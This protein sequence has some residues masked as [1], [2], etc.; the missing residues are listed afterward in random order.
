MRV[1]RK[2]DAAIRVLMGLAAAE[3]AGER[4]VPLPRLGKRTSIS[5]PFLQ[6]ILFCLRKA[7]LVQGMRGRIGGYALA[8]PAGRITAG[9]VLRAIQGSVAPTDCSVE[10]HKP[11]CGRG[12]CAIRQ[13]WLRVHRETGRIV[14]R[15]TVKEL[16]KKEKRG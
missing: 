10:G 9:D 11:I 7:R 3:E 16:M 13:V 1:T 12:F 5:G 2:A 8:K 15:V 4:P 6:Q 14:D